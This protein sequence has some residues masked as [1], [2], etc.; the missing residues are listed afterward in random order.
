MFR[1]ERFA[2]MSKLVEVFRG[3]GLGAQGLGSNVG[4]TQTLIPHPLERPS[5]V[6]RRYSTSSWVLPRRAGYK[7]LGKAED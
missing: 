6:S 2:S 4:F 5:L 3:L 1:A 7:G